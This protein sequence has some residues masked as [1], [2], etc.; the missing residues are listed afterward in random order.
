[1]I[2]YNIKLNKKLLLK[3]SLMIMTI[4]C[5][6]LTVTCIYNLFFSKTS[7]MNL[8]DDSIP[9]SEPAEITSSNYT[10]ILKQVHNNLDTYVGQKISFTGYVYRLNN[11]NSKQFVLARD[12]DIGNNQ[13]LIVGF[14]CEYDKINE[15]EDS[16]WINIEGE[17]TKGFYNNDYIPLIKITKIDRTDMPI[18][19][20]VPMPDDSYV[21]TAVI[22]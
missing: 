13:T 19:P 2:I 16:T 10:N 22:Y 14:L 7:S 15:F 20:N 11:F 6:S 21:P 12:M 9:S 4:I 18:N 5:I 3:A 17:I 1:M 8:I